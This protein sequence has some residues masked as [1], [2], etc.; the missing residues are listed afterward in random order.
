LPENLILRKFF[1]F[2]SVVL[3]FLE[4]ASPS[5]ENCLADPKRT[6]DPSLRTTG[7]I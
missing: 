7:L 3:I 5:P 1:F 2:R 4:G 6:A